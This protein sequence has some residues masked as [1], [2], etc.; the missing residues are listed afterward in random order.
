MAYLESIQW[1]MIKKDV[2]KG[3]EKGMAAMK[4][5]AIVL[6]K[7]TEEFTEEGKRQ[8]KAFTLK[9]RIHQAITDLGA[10]AYV[11]MSGSKAKNPALDAGVKNIMARIRDLKAR[12]AI[13][14][15]KGSEARSKTRPKGAKRNNTQTRRA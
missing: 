1:D 10:K 2:Q 15:G 9:V 11:I 7:K 6:R 14:E 3:L 12:L 8:Y 5:G 13:L 4:H